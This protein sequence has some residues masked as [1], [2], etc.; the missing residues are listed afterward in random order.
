MPNTG[1]DRCKGCGSGDVVDD[2]GEGVAGADDDDNGNRAE[3]RA[4]C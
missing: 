4:G 2:E 1:V 3:A